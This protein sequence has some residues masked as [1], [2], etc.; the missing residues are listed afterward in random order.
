MSTRKIPEVDAE[1]VN[2]KVTIHNNYATLEI[3]ILAVL[4]LYYMWILY[5][6]ADDRD[7]DCPSVDELETQCARKCMKRDDDGC[8]ECM[9]N[10]S[11]MY[12]IAIYWSTYITHLVNYIQPQI[13]GHYKYVAS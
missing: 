1:F 5:F 2:V 11:G 3:Y 4:D 9:D 6:G 10:C 8:L 13:N 12:Y 7:D